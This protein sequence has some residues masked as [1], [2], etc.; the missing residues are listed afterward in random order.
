MNTY[1][2]IADLLVF[3][4]LLYVGYVVIGQL[5]IVIGGVVG[6]QWVRNIWF[7]MSHLLAIGFVAFEELINMRC[8]LSVWEENLRD[9]AGQEFSGETFM[10]RL[11][12]SMM[13]FECSPQTFSLMHL[14][15]AGLVI[16]TL[17][18]LPPRLS[19]RH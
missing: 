12:H 13:F 11:I 19:S 16:G 1:A 15:F 4:H 17:I 5:L 2:V 10:A 7:R 6:W 9:L 3:V 18:L 8:P 14:G